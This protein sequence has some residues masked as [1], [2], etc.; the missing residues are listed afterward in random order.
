MGATRGIDSESGFD[1]KNFFVF[2]L[3]LT[4]RIDLVEIKPLNHIAAMF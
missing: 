2:W 1:M 4:K 3:M